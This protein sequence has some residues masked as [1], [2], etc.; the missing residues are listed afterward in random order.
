MELARPSTRDKLTLGR[1]HVPDMDES[2]VESLFDAWTLHDMNKFFRFVERRRWM[3]D[4]SDQPVDM[5][6]MR[7]MHAVYVAHYLLVS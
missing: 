5:P 3:D 4:L 1:R 2:D 7:D 6:S